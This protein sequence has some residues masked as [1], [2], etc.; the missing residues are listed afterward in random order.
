MVSSILVD[1]VK[2]IPRVNRQDQGIS[3]EGPLEVRKMHN[4]EAAPWPVADPLGWIRGLDP[5][6]LDPWGK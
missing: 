6:G 4:E 1:P 3:L 2:W 5:G